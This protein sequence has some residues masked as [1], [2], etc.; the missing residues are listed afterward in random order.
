MTDHFALWHDCSVVCV[1]CETTGYSPNT[2]D[3]I[4]EIAAVLLVKMKIV[5]VWH[6]YVNPERSIPA[7][8]SRVHGIYDEDVALAPLFRAQARSFVAFCDGAVP[9]AYNESFDRSFILAELPEGTPLH[10]WPRW[11]CPLTWVRSVDR[12]TKD[13][14][15]AQV[16]NSLSAAAARY[17]VE[18]SG[19]HGALADATAAAQILAAIHTDIPR[20]TISELLRRQSDMA[21][22]YER[23]KDRR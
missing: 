4:V 20:C 16:S 1:D 23:R 9:C 2:G 22:A 7:D 19:A 21:N 6:S 12:F 15:G 18:L 10:E 17:G 13:E 8:A 11:L 5:D 3:R 14:K